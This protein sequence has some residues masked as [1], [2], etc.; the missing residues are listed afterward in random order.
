MVVDFETQLEEFFGRR[1]VRRGRGLV[2][3]ETGRVFRVPRTQRAYTVFVASQLRRRGGTRLVFD[4]VPSRYRYTHRQTRYAITGT[5]RYSRAVRTA[6]LHFYNSLPPA[7]RSEGVGLHLFY[8]FIGSDK[9]PKLPHIREAGLPQRYRDEEETDPYAHE[10]EG[11]SMTR[12]HRP[13]T[14]T[15]E[16]LIRTRQDLLAFV[17][18]H[19]IDRQNLFDV[20]QE[21]DDG[22]EYFRPNHL[23]FS[24]WQSRLNRNEG[25]GDKQ[26]WLFRE[27]LHQNPSGKDDCVPQAIVNFFQAGKKP[28]H[29]TVAEIRRQTGLEGPISLANLEVLE[30]KLVVK[31]KGNG[32]KRRNL[33]I[34]VF[35]ARLN[36]VR[37]PKYTP[38]PSRNNK[39]LLHLVSFNK[40]AYAF[41]KP[42]VG[43]SILAR[44]ISYFEAALRCAGRESTY[45]E[46][47][48]LFRETQ[49]LR[50]DTEAIKTYLEKK[51]RAKLD[52]RIHQVSKTQTR[53][54]P[55]F[56]AE[57]KKTPQLYIDPA[58]TKRVE[59]G[60]ENTI[61]FDIETG[62]ATN[63]RF[64]TYAIR[65][66]H[67]NFSKELVA[68]AVEDLSGA[69]VWRA[70]RDWQALASRRGDVMYVYAHNGSR[71]DAIEVLYALLSHSDTIP[72]DYLVSNGK[73]IS[74]RW[75]QLVFRDSCLITMSSLKAAATSYGLK[76]TK[77]YMPH[78]YLQNCGSREELL[79][80]LHAD[81]TWGDLEPYMDWFSDATDG[82]LHH[83]EAGR[84]WE[85][86]RDEQ[87][88]RKF[89]L[90]EKDT[91]FNF[92]EK[93]S[94]YLAKDVDVLWELVEKMG[95]A[96]ATDL[97]AD[98][99]VRCT[100][101][102]IAELKWRS[103]LPQ[104]IPKLMTQERHE[105]WQ[106]VN[107]GGFCGPLS[108]FDTTCGEGE[109][110]YKVDVTS[111]Y[112][113]SACPVSYETREGLQKPLGEW[114]RGFPDA[115]NGW[116][117][118][119]F[120][121]TEMGQAE[122]EQLSSMHGLVEIEFDQTECKFPVLLKKMTCKSWQTLAPVLVG[123][124]FYTIPQVRQA[125]YYGVKIRL[126]K[127][128]YTESAVEPFQAYMEHF[129]KI[130][131]AADN[132]KATAKKG[133]PEYTKA[134]FD[135]TLA[136]LFLNGL[137]GRINMRLERQ[138]TLITRAANDVICLLT[139]RE[140]YRG[141]R[142]EELNFGASSALRA[143]FKEGSYLDHLKKFNVA[144]HL[145]GYMLGYSKMLMQESFQFLAK[146][147]STS[148]YTDTDSIAFT[149][150]PT[151]WRAYQDRFVATKKT[152]GSMEL[153]GVYD[154]LLTIGPKKYACFKA[155]GSYDWCCNGLPAR[156]NTKT[157]IQK[158]FE[159]VLA[160]KVEQISYFSINSSSDFR[161]SHTLDAV[162]T[163]R[164]LSLKGKCIDGGITWW[165][166]EEEFQQYASSLKPI[167]WGGNQRA[168]ELG[169]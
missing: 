19:L 163:L 69:L 149:A 107:R 137:L 142:I 83:R 55:W 52:I 148:I 86:W 7:W 110:I 126:G 10:Y 153:E 1:L 136:K 102:S 46:A 6:A 124:E 48:E 133:S 98:I 4:A 27:L 135:R 39:W 104:K 37:L 118:C 97:G 122:Y 91:K 79:R 44:S 47:W 67:M 34:A 166:T 50:P 155:S 38:D 121:G 161:L 131:N 90:R 93:M 33:G 26:S 103:T 80:R 132:V 13:R 45:K 65:Y 42:R 64:L 23:R 139:D 151:Q 92:R 35:D 159:D 78:R 18:D 31:G 120:G 150:T 157:D 125:F 105:L 17:R 25:L 165:A 117:T 113:A 60:M 15:V 54:L 87:P 5:G 141:T 146:I 61:A 3:P 71:F 12:L 154:R 168:K 128:E 108:K 100:V 62:S 75:G 68:E 20:Y 30:Q 169:N 57:S 63:G 29:L 119:D 53:Y 76:T 134:I 74:F 41:Q 21:A 59:H 152:F 145:S 101:G 70:L 158:K 40:H 8:D 123:R 43:Q 129:G 9:Y 114:Y 94:S 36:L 49:H 51:L 95:A 77:D 32:S 112:P 89:W 81:V 162:K 84:S 156:H 130:K 28:I 88:T 116:L 72:T 82:D 16:R 22:T 160:G 56:E 140:N 127:C 111:L 167:G 14:V 147:G 24:A 85:A 66:R 58:K 96:M 109:K 138:Q 2:N 99:R 11:H 115:N 143:V 73:F 144:P 164:F 106:R